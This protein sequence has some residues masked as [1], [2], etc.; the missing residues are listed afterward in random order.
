MAQRLL[1]GLNAASGGPRIL[2]VY[3][4]DAASLPRRCM[5]HAILG[6][7]DDLVRDV[8]L[9]GIDTVIVALPPAAEHQLVETLNKLTVVPVDVQALPRRVRAPAR[10]RAGR[11]ISAATPSSTSSTGRCATGGGSP[12]RSRTAS[13]AP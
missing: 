1:R 12:S 2:G 8:R 13:S 7:V 11:A 6:S 4:D 3:D 5:G 10:R 9:Y